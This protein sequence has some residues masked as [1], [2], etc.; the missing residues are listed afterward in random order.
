MPYLDIKPPAPSPINNHPYIDPLKIHTHPPQL[1]P[2]HTDRYTSALPPHLSANPD[3]PSLLPQQGSLK[4]HV[5]R[6][7]T[8]CARACSTRPSRT[9]SDK[10]VIFLE[11]RFF[12]S[13][14]FPRPLTYIHIRIRIL[15]P[16]SRWLAS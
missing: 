6:V 1:R 2:T 11:S 10:R 15:L 8:F 14:S 12:P 4:N 13:C 9:S 16:L 3:S 7:G 5:I